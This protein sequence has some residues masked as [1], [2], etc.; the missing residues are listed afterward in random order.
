MPKKAKN[1]HKI[2]AQGGRN[3]HMKYAQEANT[4]NQLMLETVDND[5]KVMPMQ[6]LQQ[7]SKKMLTSDI[8]NM[9]V[10]AVCQVARCRQKHLCVA[11]PMHAMQFQSKLS[12][13]LL[14]RVSSVSR[15]TCLI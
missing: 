3:R 2:K 1:Q 5:I 8:R 12:I 14:I 15:M 11:M 4:S 9:L 7:S 10:Q 6:A 13:S